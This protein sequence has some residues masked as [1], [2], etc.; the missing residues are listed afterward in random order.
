[1]T[2]IYTNKREELPERDEN[3]VYETEADLALEALKG[4]PI[5]QLPGHTAFE[6]GVGSGIWGKVWKTLYPGALIDGVEIRDLPTPDG[7]N[8]VFNGDFRELPFTEKRYSVIFGNPPYKFA[9]SIIRDAWKRL[10]NGGYMVM[11]LRLAFQAG[12]ERYRGLWQ[13]LYPYEVAVCSRRPSF[14][15][16]GTNGTDY[17]LYYWRKGENGL[18][19]GTPGKWAMR[20]ICHQRSK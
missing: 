12:V 4:L 10:E 16:G 9:E 2:T 19:Y 14:Y 6:Y 17:G 20:L 18:A 13:E 3:D 1:M 5:A 7:Y 15:G 8:M 11:L